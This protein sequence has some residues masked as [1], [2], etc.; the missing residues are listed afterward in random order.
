MSD[1]YNDVPYVGTVKG[2]I[3]KTGGWYAVEIA[4]PGEQYPI[5]ADTKLENLLKSVREIRDAGLVATFTVRE[6]ESQNINPNT[7]NPYTE[8]RLQSVEAGAQNQQNATASP[9]G[10]MTGP[11][12]SG[13]EST[14]SKEEWRA[15]DRAADK[16]ALT[17]IAVSA[18]THTMPAA[19]TTE[20]LNTFLERVGHLT[21]AWQNVI[22]A[23]RDGDDPPF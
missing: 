10:G 15:K 22:D 18:L 1:E 9:S 23:V 16:R 14:M 17:A 5:K 2:L 12:S 8:R 21:L 11:T 19:P 20:D 7:G 4:V 13:A 6:S 3:E